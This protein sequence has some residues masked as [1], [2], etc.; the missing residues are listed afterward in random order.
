MQYLHATT[1]QDTSADRQLHR[2][3]TTNLIIK[4]LSDSGL[5]VFGV[6]GRLARLAFMSQGG[7]AFVTAR[8]NPVEIPID[9]AVG[10]RD[11]VWRGFYAGYAEQRLVR[12]LGAY[13]REGRSVDVAI[14]V[15]A[16]AASGNRTYEELAPVYKKILEQFRFTR[17]FT[18][19]SAASLGVVL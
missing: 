11:R 13:V 3:C 1:S 12:C 5:S 19:L 10:G 6:R 7:L 2:L 9:S 4:A 18:K 16:L 15:Q 17:A 8:E 14:L